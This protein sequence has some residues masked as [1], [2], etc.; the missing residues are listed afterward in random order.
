VVL[1]EN[2]GSTL[3]NY[4]VNFVVSYVS[5]KMKSDFSDLRFT[6]SDQ[7]TPIPYWI[8]SYTASVSASVWVKVPSIPASSTK[9]IYMYYGNSGATSA[10]NGIATFEFFDDFNDGVKDTNKWVTSGTVTETGG[11]LQVGSGADSIAR[12]NS[13]GYPLLSGSYVLRH[14][15][16]VSVTGSQ[17]AYIGLANSVLTRFALAPHTVNSYYTYNG[18][19]EQYTRNSA[20]QTSYATYDIVWTASS[21]RYYQNGVLMATHT[22]PPT[23]SMGAY[24]RAYTSSVYARCD[25]LLIHKYVSAEPSSVFG[26]EEAQVLGTSS[27]E[28][29]IVPAANGTVLLADTAHAAVYMEQPHVVQPTIL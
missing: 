1:T 19:T 3:S 13:T 2:S 25:W 26:P 28:M 23:V 7:V 12:Q 11:Y 21:V 18:A 9:S 8:E 6:D 22:N 27:T 16:L 15:G 29:T 14:R 20:G 24:L 4:Q 17:Y 5:S 10:S